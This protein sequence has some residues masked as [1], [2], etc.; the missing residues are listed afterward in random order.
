MWKVCLFSIF[1]FFWISPSFSLMYCIWSLFGQLGW[2]IWSLTFWYILQMLLEQVK[3]KWRLPQEVIIR[4]DF[5]SNS[6]IIIGLQHLLMLLEYVSKKYWSHFVQ[7]SFKNE[8]EYLL[9]CLCAVSLMSQFQWCELLN[10]PYARCLFRYSETSL[11]Q[12]T[13][14]NNETLKI[15]LQLKFKCSWKIFIVLLVNDTFMHLK[16]GLKL[17]IYCAPAPFQKLYLLRCRC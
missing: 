12:A 11:S 4:T 1:S 8:K 16:L 14:L 5:H 6:F 9:K 15:S 7:V 2:W 3:E 13:L 17:Y 10:F